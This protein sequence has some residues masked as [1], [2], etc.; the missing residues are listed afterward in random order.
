MG[1]IIIKQKFVMFDK[2]ELFLEDKKAIISLVKNK[3][4][5]IQT[6]KKL[7]YICS[8]YNLGSNLHKPEA[9]NLNKKT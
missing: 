3:E 9:F 6:Q 1:T 7:Y 4:T 8:K 5:L 2:S